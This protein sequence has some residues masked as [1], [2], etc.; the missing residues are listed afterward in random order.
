V[1]PRN[2]IISFYVNGRLKFVS[3]DFKEPMFRELNEHWS[4]QEGVAFNLSLMMG[5]QGL[6][7][8]ILSDKPEDYDRYIFP[9]ERHFAGNICG[10]LAYFKMNDCK[11]SHKY[12]REKIQLFR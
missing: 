12:I 9:I 5:S 6:L 1:P 4:K 2:G 11:L 10:L 3:K 8:T 7:E